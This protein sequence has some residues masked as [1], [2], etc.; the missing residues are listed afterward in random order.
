[1]SLYPNLHNAVRLITAD[2]IQR[3]VHQLGQEITNTYGVGQPLTVVIVLTGA[4]PFAMD[5]IRQL[6]LQVTLE[7]VQYSSY[8]G[9]TVG[10]EV[11]RIRSVPS[12]KLRGKNVLL[13][14]DILDRGITMREALDDM[15]TTIRVNWPKSIRTCVLLDKNQA[16]E[17]QP[18][19][20]VVE[21][22]FTGFVI[23]NKFVIGYGLDLNECYRNLPDIYELT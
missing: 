11:K 8:Q 13:V 15:H 4:L 10:K 16:V 7:F 6:E 22:D 17:R 1:M 21:A 12:E 3:R 19:N 2:R 9:G 20:A 14:D 23:P 18:H 5:L